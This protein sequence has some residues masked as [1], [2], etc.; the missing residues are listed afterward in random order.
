MLIGEDV[1]KSLN[2]E[3]PGKFAVSGAD[4][5]ALMAFMPSPVCGFSEGRFIDFEIM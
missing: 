5:P 3:A 4:D 1:V 2:L